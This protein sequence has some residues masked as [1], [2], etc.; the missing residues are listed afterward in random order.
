MVIEHPSWTSAFL[1]DISCMCLVGKTWNTSAEWCRIALSK[2]W[3]K[4]QLQMTYADTA[5]TE[6]SMGPY[7]QTH[8]WQMP[9]KCYYQLLYQGFKQ[10]IIPG[11]FWD[12]SIS[13]Y[14]NINL[15]CQFNLRL[16]DSTVQSTTCFKG[17]G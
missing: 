5:D 8:V 7:L 2:F 9:G 15:K 6:V 12:K 17:S 11:I 10:N 16:Q 3:A 13:L 1:L 4:I 14:M